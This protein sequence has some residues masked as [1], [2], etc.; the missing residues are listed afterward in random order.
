M[1]IRLFAAVVT[2][3]AIAL[4]VGLGAA[5][6]MAVTATWTVMPGGQFYTA[7]SPSNQ[8]FTD[9]TTGT[10]IRCSDLTISGTFKSGSGLPNPVG[11]VTSVGI[12]AF[13]PG[14]S[15][16]CDVGVSGQT[17]SFTFSPMNIRAVRYDPTKDLT[18]GAFVAVHATFSGLG[19]SACSGTLDGTSP[20]AGNG[21]VRFKY[22]DSDGG[23]LTYF[24]GDNLHLYNVS[25]CGGLINSG[26]AL[27]FRASF[28]L[29][30]PKSGLVNTITSP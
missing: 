9:A 6:V 16:S 1:R 17:A 12:F 4:P 25:G 30:H 14:Q 5:P 15:I 28:A 24:G 20:T 7:S 10:R 29:S 18:Y 27:T 8:Y 26:D 19:G 3:A 2:G 21:L 22:N 23:L 11:R 13:D